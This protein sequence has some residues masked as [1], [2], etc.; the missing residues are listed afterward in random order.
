MQYIGYTILKSNAVYNNSQRYYLY[1]SNYNILEGKLGLDSQEYNVDLTSDSTNNLLE[2]NIF[3]DSAVSG[4]SQAYDAG[5]NNTIQYNY[6]E[7][8]KGRMLIK[9]SLGHALSVGWKYK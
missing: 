7:R 5:N 2:D 4:N 8:T 1:G 6:L 9:T 3:Y